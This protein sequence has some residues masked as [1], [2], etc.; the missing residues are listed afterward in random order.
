[1]VLEDTEERS[2][3]I[4]DTVFIPTEALC[5]CEHVKHGE[6][7]S[8]T[9]TQC[10]A[11]IESSRN[12]PQLLLPLLSDFLGGGERGCHAFAH[13]SKRQAGQA[14]DGGQSNKD[15]EAA[16]AKTTRISEGLDKLGSLLIHGPAG[17]GKSLF[18]KEAYR[19]LLQHR[20]FLRDVYGEDLLLVYITL[21]AMT[22]PLTDLFAEGL[23]RQYDLRDSQIA[24]L[25]EKIRDPN[26]KLRVVFMLDGYDELPPDVRSKNLFKSNNLETLRPQTSKNKFN[27]WPKIITLCRSEFLSEQKDGEYQQQFLPMEFM[28]ERKDEVH[29]AAQY[30]AEFKLTRFDKKLEAYLRRSVAIDVRKR[31]EDVC[32]GFP[33]PKSGD[34]KVVK[35]ILLD[36]LVA[37]IAM[38]KDGKSEAEV[39]HELQSKGTMLLSPWQLEEVRLSVCLVAQGDGQISI[40]EGKG[41]TGE[42]Q[43]SVHRDREYDR[44]LAE[45]LKAHKPRTDVGQINFDDT[46]ANDERYL[47][48]MIR[49]LRRVQEGMHSAATNMQQVSDAARPQASGLKW[50]LADTEPPNGQVLEEPK[51]KD[52]LAG[53]M[54]FKQEEWDEF[55]IKDLSMGHFIKGKE[56]S[57]FTP[58]ADLETGEQGGDKTAA[59]RTED[60]KVLAKL[61]KAEVWSVLRTLFRLG[62]VEGL[63]DLKDTPFMVHVCL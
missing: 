53:K 14:D 2:N 28:N 47:V 55:G 10:D 4:P 17:S 6:S 8:L 51:L 56:G 62:K 20:H 36:D 39:L 19:Y 45:F 50:K 12:K 58:A 3:A 48:A 23:K 22:N 34:D 26:S 29:E 42:D 46:D 7:Q 11:F 1:M 40:H 60:A 49:L 61:A 52:A 59:T 13:I 57:Y 31:F 5:R 24:E 21:P 41:A 25:K 38:Y 32:G 27:N 44:K 33:K 15:G 63:D 30:F 37:S 43:N 9:C 35:S 16:G 18:A 54:E